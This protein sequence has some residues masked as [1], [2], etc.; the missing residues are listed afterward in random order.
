MLDLMRRYVYGF[1]NSHDPE[2]ARTIMA[3]GYRLHTGNDT[4]TGRDDVYIPAVMRAIAQTPGLTYSIHDLISDGTLT[5]V[6]FSEHG[7]A[8]KRPERAASWRGVAIYR[9]EHG[10]LAECWVEQD[11]LGKRIQSETGSAEPVPPVHIDPWTNHNPPSVT[12][13]ARAVRAV[14]GW[15]GSLATWPPTGEPTFD[16]GIAQHIQPRISV[17]SACVNVV[18]AEGS[19][20]AF[21]ATVSGIYGGG[22]PGGD[23]Q[24][25]SAVMLSFG[26]FGTVA[27]GKLIEIDGVSG[28]LS[29]QNQLRAAAGT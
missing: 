5:A 28:R 11:H 20:A 25:G 9:A 7:R 22:L 14:D 16:R 15:L 2:V 8:G 13:A 19:R 27:A 23:A 10:R 26:G 21:N 12:A 1:V 6:L 4:L 24:I 17:T 29:V 3:P 18:V